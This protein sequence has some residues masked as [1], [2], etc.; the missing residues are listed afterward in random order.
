M[1]AEK[2]GM[3]STGPAGA[4]V[5]WYRHPWPWAFIGMLTATVIAGAVTLYLAVSTSDGLVADDYYK[6]GLGINK[7]LA[8]SERAAALDLAGTLRLTAGEVSVVLSGRDGAP[9]AENLRAIFAHPTRAGLDRI[10]PLER[11]GDAWRGRSE[12]LPPGRWR[13]SIEDAP[14]TW[15]LN[16]VAHFPEDREIA[17]SAAPFKSID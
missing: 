7:Q 16:A 10:I 15:R 8:R 17:L 2:P 12:P 4:T 1:S 11:A 3:G 14:A 13:V 5:P 6:Q 9:P